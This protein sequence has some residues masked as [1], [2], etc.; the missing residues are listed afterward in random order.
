MTWKHIALV[1]ILIA[2]LL[3]FLKIT[4]STE[5]GAVPTVTATKSAGSLELVGSRLNQLGDVP[6]GGGLVMTEFRLRNPGD[7][8]V[9]LL[10]G[11]TSCMCTTAVIKKENGEISRRI[12]MPGHGGGSTGRLNMTLE[13]RSEATVIATFDPM[14]HGP[15]ATGPIQ[16]EVILQTNSKTTPEVRLFFNGNVTPE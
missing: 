2:G 5:T 12:E 3:V 6:I 8:P 14:A 1:G 16:R 13:P 15:G 4:S 11:E 9:E 7:E 10:A